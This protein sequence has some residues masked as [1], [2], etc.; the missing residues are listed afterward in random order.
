VKEFQRRE[1]IIEGSA[2]KPITLDVTAPAASSNHT[3]VIIFCHGFKGFKDWGHFNLLAE[4]FAQEKFIFIKFNFSYNG[5]TPESLMD[6]LDIEAFGQNNFSRELNDLGLV[7][8]WAET[9][10]NSEIALIG[11]SRGGGIS[12]LKAGEDL[13]V[14]KIVSWASPASFE[15]RY[16]PQQL[17]YW[18]TVG[19]IYVENSRT[20][21]QM[22]LY[23]QMVE[24]FLANKTRIDIEQ[25]LTIINKPVLI[26]HGKKDEV[27]GFEEA[28]QMKKWKPEIQLHLIEAANH[29]FGISHP[30]P[31]A[32]FSS[33][34][35][36]VYSI[37][38][39][40]LKGHPEIK[41]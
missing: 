37:T 17:E 1:L 36:Q 33:D 31:H 24:D 15:N 27:I 40:F 41:S 30:Y 34:F 10:Y 26:I 8:D 32:E 18:K 7:I 2:G 16:T 3:S 20:K 11:H 14:K 21:Q 19:V 6:F 28:L 9:N 25:A 23:Y 22:P 5:T 13:R 39:S 38:L 12:I 29:T 35:E 4:K